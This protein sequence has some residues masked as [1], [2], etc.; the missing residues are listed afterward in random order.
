MA[1]LANSDTGLGMQRQFAE[2]SGKKE[3]KKSLPA[4]LVHYRTEFC[5]HHIP[6]P[7]TIPSSNSCTLGVE[8]T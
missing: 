8:V 5:S 4:C 2:I 1:L 3:K 6:L 7:P